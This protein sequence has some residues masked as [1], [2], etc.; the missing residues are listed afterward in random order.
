MVRIG[1]KFTRNIHRGLMH[2][3]QNNNIW[4]GCVK[5]EE[6]LRS[7]FLNE[8]KFQC[9]CALYNLSQIE[10]YKNQ[11]L[12]TDSYQLWVSLQGFLSAT[13]NLS[14]IFWPPDNLYKDRGEKL[15]SHLKISRSSAIRSRRFRNYIEHFD[16]KLHE[17]AAITNNHNFF[18]KIIVNGDIGSAT[19]GSDKVDIVRYFNLKSMTF[20]FQGE[21]LTL[22]PVIE[23]IK[24]IYNKLNP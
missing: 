24:I 21:E 17:W 4:K 18:D 23:E 14:K 6:R 5:M 1:F 9:E 22:Q 8:I 13:A 2:S 7:I 16:E 11:L 20:W 15:R 10:N 12:P 3:L 19:N